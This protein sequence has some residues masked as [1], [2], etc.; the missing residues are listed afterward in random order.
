[1]LRIYL[2]LLEVSHASILERKHRHIGSFS[3]RRQLSTSSDSF[4]VNST[5]G[6]SRESK[7]KMMTSVCCVGTQPKREKGKKT[8]QKTKHS[9]AEGG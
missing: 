4:H 8:K 9:K 3:L 5:Y 6:G 7:G 1:M 2:Y